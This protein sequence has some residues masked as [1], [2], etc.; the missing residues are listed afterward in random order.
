MSQIDKVYRV[1]HMIG[2]DT[3]VP[4]HA[5]NHRVRVFIDRTAAIKRAKQ[6]KAV[7]LESKVVWVPLSED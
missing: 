7:V 2:E 6:E 3:F 5:Y 4:S 1:V